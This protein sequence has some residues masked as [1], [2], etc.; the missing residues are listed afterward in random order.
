LLGWLVAGPIIGKSI[1]N[2]F[3]SDNDDPTTRGEAPPPAQRDLER[4]SERR[5]RRATPGGRG[6]QRPSVNRPPGLWRARPRGS[7][8][9]VS[10]VC[11]RLARPA[12]SSSGPS[13]SRAIYPS[14]SSAKK[15]ITNDFQASFEIVDDRRAHRFEDGAVQEKY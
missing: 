3:G 14:G 12:L 2:I 5:A 7:A 13:K 10:A 8:L 4:R 11:R 6:R 15:R 1:P 9:P